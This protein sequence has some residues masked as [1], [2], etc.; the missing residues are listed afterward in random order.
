MNN[1]VKLVFVTIIV[2]ISIAAKSQIIFN[3]DSLFGDVKSLTERIL[4]KNNF[5]DTPKYYWTCIEYQFDKYS[6]ITNKYWKSTG[7]IGAEITYVF[8][9]INQLIEY[10]FFEKERLIFTEVYKYDKKGNAI[11]IKRNCTD[12]SKN[13]IE[14]NRYDKLGNVVKIKR[15]DASMKRFYVQKFLYK[16]ND[17]DSIIEKK[18]FTNSTLDET[19]SFSFDNIENIREYKRYSPSGIIV[20]HFYDNFRWTYNDVGKKV[21][22]ERLS[23]KDEV[24]GKTVFEYD[25]LGNIISINKYDVR[26]ELCKLYSSIKYTYKFD[27]ERNWIEKFVNEDESEVKVAERQIEYFE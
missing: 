13:D 5:T 24:I 21:K 15:K 25:T 16:Y 8:N 22:E 20:G 6:N 7:K 19:E 2:T 3:G 17:V 12:E 10:S 14:I 4:E 27:H 9:N 18:H 23:S 1:I 11:E 26:G